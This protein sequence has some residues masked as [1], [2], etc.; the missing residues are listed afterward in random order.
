[1]ILPPPGTL[2]ALGLYLLR[3]SALVL[4]S[5][6]IGTGAT[7][8]GYKLGLIGVLAGLLYSLAG[9]PTV[10]DVSVLGLGILGLRELLIG[11]SLAFA[12][13]VTVLAT[14]VGSELIGHEMVFNMAS[15]VDPGSGTR[16][17]LIAHIYEM[18]FFLAFLAVDGHHWLIRALAE[19]YERAPVARFHLSNGLPA[20][21][22]DQF[23]QMFAA[24]MTLAAPVLVLLVLIS[25]MLGLLTR[26]VPQINVLEFGFSLR[27]SGG[28]VAMY[29]FAPMLAPALDRLLGRLMDGLGHTLDVLGT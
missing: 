3:T 21:A 5:P 29:L 8:S 28:L 27:I 20:V 11:M 18:F 17:P 13:H 6:L 14:R 15:V 9:F 4:A 1:M 19:S 2:E 22:L 26:A 23:G 10:P 12:L 16:V 24:G 25:L 7:F